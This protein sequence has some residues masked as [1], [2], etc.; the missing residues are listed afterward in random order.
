VRSLHAGGDPRRADVVRAGEVGASVAPAA[1]RTARTVLPVLVTVKPRTSPWVPT[2]SPATLMPAGGTITET[3]PSVTIRPTSVM[4]LCMTMPG[5]AE[6]VGVDFY[7]E[8][9]WHVR[10]EQER[11]ASDAYRQA[12]SELLANIASGETRH[13]SDVHFGRDVV[14]VLSRCQAVL[15]HR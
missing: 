8:H 9:G 12:L 13:R 7:D 6:R 15:D 14:E 1:P 5:G 3:R 11:D 4:S 2:P 10:P